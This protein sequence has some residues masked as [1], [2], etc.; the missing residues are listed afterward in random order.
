M[1]TTQP[2]K[3]FAFGGNLINGCECPA[4]AAEMDPTGIGD[5]H[6]PGLLEAAEM[7]DG[8]VQQ[9]QEDREGVVGEDIA[10]DAWI[11]MMRNK[12]QENS[13]MMSS[14][15]EVAKYHGWI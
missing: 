15:E 11:E 9:K 7:Y 12:V 3:T 2:T 10:K 5:E 4:L 1:S 14:A 6:I 8:I 13:A